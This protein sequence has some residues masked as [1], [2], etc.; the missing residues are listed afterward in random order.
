[1]RS[2]LIVCVALVICNHRFVL[3]LGVS[4]LLS[5]LVSGM[6]RRQFLFFF[7]VLSFFPFLLSNIAI[8]CE[9]TL[10]KIVISYNIISFPFLSLLF[11]SLFLLR[12]RA[13][14]VSYLGKTHR[15]RTL[16]GAH[17]LLFFLALC[18]PT[19][20]HHLLPRRMIGFFYMPTMA[21]HG[22]EWNTIKESEH[23]LT[24]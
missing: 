14:R 19:R 21:W 18:R 16:N 22:G 15:H 3:L 24:L 12:L 6:G 23:K 2:T 17:I 7:N 11:F 1:M 5:V 4:L 8:T 13:L 9:K 20:A 10:N